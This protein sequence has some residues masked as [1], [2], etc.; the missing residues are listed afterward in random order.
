[1]EVH[2]RMK[3]GRPKRIWLARVRDDIKENRLS[4]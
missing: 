1:M 4:G 2:G 3:G